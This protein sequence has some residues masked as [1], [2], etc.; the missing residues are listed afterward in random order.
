MLDADR[1]Q[2]AFHVCHNVA[3]AVTINA[4]FTRFELVPISRMAVDDAHT[5][6]VPIVI[7]ILW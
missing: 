3:Q 6:F 5:L 2:L 4:S 7:Y 1:K